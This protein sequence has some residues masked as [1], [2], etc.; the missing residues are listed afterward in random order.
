M[1]SKQNGKPREAARLWKV[2]LQNGEEVSRDIINY[3][4]YAGTKETIKVGV[5]SDNPQDTEKMNQVIGTKNE[6]EIRRVMNEILEEQ[7]NT[8][9]NEQQNSQPDTP[10]REQSGEMLRYRMNR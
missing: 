5:A 10:S 9:K 7:K 8:Q 3:S 4:Q 6:D 1:E 2:V